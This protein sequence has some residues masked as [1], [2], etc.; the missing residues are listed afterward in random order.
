MSVTCARLSDDGRSSASL[1]VSTWS[2]GPG[3]GA[4]L[5]ER[6]VDQVLVLGEGLGQ[7]GEVLDHRAD[8]AVPAGQRGRHRVEVVEQAPDG[9]R[10]VRPGRSAASRPRPAARLTRASLPS[11]APPT[12]V[13]SGLNC[14]GSTAPT[15]P[16]QLVDQRADVDH[17]PGALDL[18]TVRQRALRRRPGT[19]RPPAGRGGCASAR[20]PRSRSGCARPRPGRGVTR[21][22][23]SSVVS[24]PDD[25]ADLD[26]GD[27]H[28]VAVAQAGHVVEGR[29]VQVVGVAELDLG[30]LGPD[31]RGQARG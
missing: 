11:R 20:R 24:M 14:A 10:P 18:V 31:E 25:L 16:T 5:G 30:D 8:L 12:A 21:A 4:Q 22:V 23:P 19:G 1:S 17:R 6:A 29:P 9:R 2:A 15:T 27:L 7:Q 3:V 28:V 13:T 26:A